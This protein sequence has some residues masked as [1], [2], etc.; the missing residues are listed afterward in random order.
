LPRAIGF[1]NVTGGNPMPSQAKQ[2]KVRV[3]FDPKRTDIEALGFAVDKVLKAAVDS[4]LFEE[5]GPVEFSP[6]TCA[7]VAYI[8]LDGKVRYRDE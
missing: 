7:S 6:T 1:G 2:L 3:G 5:Y 4:G 8:D